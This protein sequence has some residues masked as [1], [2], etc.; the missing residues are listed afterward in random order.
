VK[1][2]AT[3]LL[4]PVICI[5]FGGR[6][7]AVDIYGYFEPQYASFDTRG[8]YSEIFSNKLRVDLAASPSEHASLAANF[9][10]ITYH[11]RTS[12]NLLDYMPE[13]LA[14]A[15]PP[16][17][18]GRF[19]LTYHDSVFLDNAYLKLAFPAFDVTAGKQQISLGTGYVWNPTDLFNFKDYVDPTY[20]QPGHNCVR[21][22]MPIGLRYGL[23]AIYLPDGDWDRSGK[24]IRIRGGESH[25]DF[26][27]TFIERRWWLS[28]FTGGTPIESRRRLFGGETVGELLGLGVWTEFGY[29][30]MTSHY[31]FWEAVAGTDY[32]LANE[33]YLMAE[34]YYN[35]LA[36]DDYNEYSLND[37]MRFFLAESK[38]IARH[39]LYIYGE[40]PL[41][42]LMTINNSIVMS[43]SDRSLA[44]VPGL[45][46]SLFQ[47]VQLTVFI[48]VNTGR[49]GTAYDS[50]QGSGGILRLRAY[51]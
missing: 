11:G 43:L 30:L 5:F 17:F 8:E 51:F 35:G 26:A 32:T 14:E 49:S 31:D 47:D 20:E 27:A 44:L 2:P 13:S 18:M 6:T 9:D 38:S 36:K 21:F 37:W 50:D 19:Q 4:L 22:D 33:T 40:Y 42:D 23:S 3:L 7:G 41:T 25:F 29:N 39:N 24:L 28:D 15:V 1:W 12:Y 34:Y 48:S 46:Y 45:G 10:Y 16:Q